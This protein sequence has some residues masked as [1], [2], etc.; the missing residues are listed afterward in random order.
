M[1]T[2]NTPVPS[3]VQITLPSGQVSSR[4]I[5]AIMPSS[6]PIGWSKHSTAAYYKEK[7]ALW[8]KKDID[9][10]IAT[11]QNLVYRYANYKSTSPNALYLRINQAI[12]YLCDFMDDSNTYKKFLEDVAIHRERGVGITI[13]FDEVLVE[14]TGGEFI[15]GSKLN[16]W[17]KD[18]D[19]YLESADTDGQPFYKNGLI[20]NESE[21]EQLKLELAGL[22]NIM[23]SITSGEVKVMKGC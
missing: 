10:M 18:L 11:R 19:D 4:L 5:N 7:Y 14:N 1:N 15:D 8:L 22:S 20:L 6:K 16:S 23:Y 17:R 12:R 3:T 13:K 9:K 21:I 2:N